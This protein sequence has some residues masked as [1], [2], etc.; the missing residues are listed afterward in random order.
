MMY[1]QKHC[2]FYYEAKC[3]KCERGEPPYLRDR[4]EVAS[5]K[6]WERLR[7]KGWTK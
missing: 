4:S 1:C 7:L 3:D 6:E 2:C 5:S